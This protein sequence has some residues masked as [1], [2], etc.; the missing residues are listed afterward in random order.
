MLSCIGRKAAPRQLYNSR[1]PLE[2]IKCHWLAYVWSLFHWHNFKYIYI[3][4]TRNHSEYDDDIDEVEKKNTLTAPNISTA[5]IKWMWIKER[6]KKTNN[7]KQAH[8]I[9]LKQ[10]CLKREWNVCDASI[11]APSYHWG[12]VVLCRYRKIHFIRKPMLKT[13]THLWHGNQAKKDEPNTAQ[14][15]SKCACLN[16]QLHWFYTFSSILLSLTVGYFFF[17]FIRTV[18]RFQETIQNVKSKP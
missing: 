6:K 18:S 5:P 16:H 1:V 15:L 8:K 10:K 12:A 17:S 14:Q 3:N 4:E 9:M 13:N 7:T 11:F 2:L